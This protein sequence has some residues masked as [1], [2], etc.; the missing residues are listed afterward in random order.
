MEYIIQLLL[1]ILIGALILGA[2]LGI[3]YLVA[4]KHWGAWVVIFIAFSGLLGHVILDY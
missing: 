1:R 3:V 4:T 2:V